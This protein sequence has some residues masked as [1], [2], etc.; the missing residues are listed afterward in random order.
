M[1]KKQQ[2]YFILFCVMIGWGFNV[3]ATK[4]LVANFMPVTMTALRIFTAAVSVFVIL[5]LMKKVRKLTRREFVYVL[6]GALFNVVGHHYFLSNGLAH[7]SASNGGLIL[8]TGPILTTVLAI[9]FLGDKVTWPRIIGVLLGISGVAFIVLEGG[10]GVSSISLGD[11]Y[12]FLAILS[13]AI[14]FIIIKRVS[15]TLDPRL[16]TGYM[17]LIGSVILFVISQIIEP[18]GLASMAHGSPL[19]WA[20]FFSSAIIA[21]ALGHMMYNDAVGKIGAAEASI[22]INLNPFFALI[23]A[24]VFLGEKI[25]ATQMIGFIFILF[26]VLLGSG[27]FEDLLRTKRKKEISAKI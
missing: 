11:V 21:T 24:V 22:F 8:G 3:I 2:I 13:Q 9:L 12:V 10:G 25:A 7:T 27:A 6:I 14:S 26:G 1:V 16:M 20:A 5:L 17:L 4:V 15:G 19:L 23:G 18:N